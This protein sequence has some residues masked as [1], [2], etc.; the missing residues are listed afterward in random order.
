MLGNNYQANN[1]K[2][3]RCYAVAASITFTI[4]KDE[5]NGF[6]WRYVLRGYNW[7]AVLDGPPP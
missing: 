6:F 7:E 5:G 1:N 3:S 4:M 2:T